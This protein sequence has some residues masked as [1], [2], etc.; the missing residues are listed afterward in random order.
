M[1][2]EITHR[3]LQTAL[4]AAD[5]ARQITRRYFRSPLGVDSKPDQSPVTVADRETEQAL[6]NLLLERF[7]EH[8]FV[9]EESGCWGASAAWQ[10]VVD[11]ID[12]TAAFIS[13]RPTFGTLIALLFERRPMLGIIDHA[14]LNERWVGV[15]GQATRYNGVACKTRD[16]RRLEHASLYATSPDMFT[17]SALGQ[18]ERLSAG[19]RFRAF[20]G[21]CYNYGLLASGFIDIVCEAGL[22]PYDYCALV[23]AVQGAGG[24]ISDW[25]GR[26]VGLDSS[27]Q[28]L[29]SANPRLHAHAL[30]KL[31]A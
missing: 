3:M 30:E 18:F 11:P 22:Q 10:W 27:G 12:G 2:P 6:K 7:P 5:T 14:I 9:G 17:A 31:A 20:G 8:G 29:A 21:D 4:Q 24:V 25:S 26:A 28:I 23:P 15:A 19:A 16:T 1:A 13:G